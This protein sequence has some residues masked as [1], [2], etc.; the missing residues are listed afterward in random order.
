MKPTVLGITLWLIIFFPIGMYL[1]VKRIAYNAA[2]ITSERFI[3]AYIAQR[4]GL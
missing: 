4:R 3:R 1:L 2:E